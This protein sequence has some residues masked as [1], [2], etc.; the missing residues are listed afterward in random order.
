MHSPSQSSARKPKYDQ[1][2]TQYCLEIQVV[3]TEDDKVIPPP[4]HTWQA[5]IVE[6]MVWEGRVG[7]MEA[8]VTGP[9]WV[10]LFYGRHLLGEGLSLGE[11]RDATFTLSGVI[12]WVGKQAQ[13]STKPISLGEGR[14]LIAKAITEGHIKPWG[15]SHPHS[16]PPVSVPF[17]FRNH[18]L[19][20]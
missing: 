15:P 19:S 9:G 12:A 5:P 6:D 18:D 13:L 3:Y 7:L 17:N 1:P 16:I 14:Q 4:T 20:P 11:A 2:E 10:V 8:I